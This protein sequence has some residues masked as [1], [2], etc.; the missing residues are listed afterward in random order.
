MLAG[1]VHYTINQPLMFVLWY[2]RE[3]ERERERKNKWEA[4]A[5]NEGSTCR[6]G[7]RD[8]D[9]DRD[10]R[11]TSIGHKNIM[12]KRERAT[13]TKRITLQECSDKKLIKAVH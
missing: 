12:H 1:T 4:I 10:E 11:N 2:P 8:P 5:G 7:K 9:S 3:R 6:Y 13:A